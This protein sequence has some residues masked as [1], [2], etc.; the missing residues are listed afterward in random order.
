MNSLIILGVA[1]S[2][3]DLVNRGLE[4]FTD[5]ENGITSV[6]MQISATILLFLAVRFLLWNKVTEVIEER[7]RKSQEVFDALNQAKLDTQAIYDKALEDERL[8]KEEANKIIERAK[9]KSYLEAEEIIN[10]ANIEANLRLEK[11]KE[12]IE[13]EIQNASD[14]LK[15]EIVNTAYLLAEKII[16]EEID[17]K[18]HEDLVSD[19]MKKV[20]QDDK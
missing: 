16:N 18:K 17:Q 1:E 9:E 12:E 2:I 20:N 8:A 5:T 14:K 6:L 13:L 15:E 10:N 7:E 19:F 11:T 4:L 3:S